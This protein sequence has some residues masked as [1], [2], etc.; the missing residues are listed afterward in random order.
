[1]ICKHRDTPRGIPLFEKLDLSYGSLR[2][3]AGIDDEQNRL[4]L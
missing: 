2:I 4:V 3:V 1:V